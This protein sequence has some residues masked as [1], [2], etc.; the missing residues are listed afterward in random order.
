MRE[1]VLL[2]PCLPEQCGKDFR[3]SLKKPSPNYPHGYKTKKPRIVPA[4]TIQGE[5]TFRFLF[6]K[7]VTIIIYWHYIRSYT[8]ISYLYA[9]NIH[10]YTVGFG[11]TK[12]LRET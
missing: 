5:I 6:A 3:Q 12:V 1:R 7:H 10:T 4:F 2:P 9:Y 11:I 8:A